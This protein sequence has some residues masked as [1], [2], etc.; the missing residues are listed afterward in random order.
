MP[1]AI[2]S[3]PDWLLTRVH[4]GERLSASV[5]ILLVANVKGKTVPRDDYDGD[6]IITE[7]LSATELDDI[8]GYF[9]QAGLYCEALLDEAGFLAWLRD[10]RSRFPRKQPLV[11]NLSQTGTG[12]ARLTTVAGLCRLYG[13]PLVDSDAHA[14]AIAQHKFHS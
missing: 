1:Q 8:V 6:S 11:Y 10:G 2:G 12:P 9:Q 5:G 7:F 4:L 3:P 14:V 13:L